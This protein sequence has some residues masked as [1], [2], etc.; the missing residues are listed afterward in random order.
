MNSHPSSQTVVVG[1]SGGV[2][3]SVSALL[4]KQQGYRVIGLFM[5]NW[6][7]QDVDGVCQSSKEYEDVLK[8]CDHLGIPC[9]TVNFTQKYWDLVFQEFLKEFKLGRTPNPD[10]L[11][12]REIKFKAMYEKAMEYGA[13]FLATGHYC[14]NIL[15]DGHPCLMKGIDLNKDQSYFLYTI[16]EDILKKVLFP[17]G[18][19][20]KPTVRQ[21]AR[22]C[23]IATSEKKDST[24]ICFIGKRDFKEFLSRY[25]AIKPG[26][27]E[28][29]KGEVVGQHDGVAYYTLGQRKGMGIGGAGEAWYVVGKDPARNVVIVDQGSRH[30]ALYCDELVATQL[31]WVSPLGLSEIPYACQ[32]KVR[33]RQTDQECLITRLE[34][35]RVHVSFKIPQR[36]VTPGQSIVFYKDSIC[37]GG[38]IIE[39]VGPSYYDRGL[40]LP[41]QVSF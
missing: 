28:N 12:N 32:S 13:D 27:F 1:L 6:E 20:Y 30:P 14:Q 25:L 29:L 7:E 19:L 22:D 40:P 11:C 10:I 41:S 8:V 2:D 26:H 5:K 36:A 39:T 23:Q 17:I 16:K 38:G 9:Y 33:Y 15:K 34:A 37:L 21:I 24:G 18:H 3:S 4:L 35:D 31:S